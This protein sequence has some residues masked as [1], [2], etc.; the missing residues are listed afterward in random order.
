MKIILAICTLL[1][2]KSTIL[3]SQNNELSIFDDMIVNSWIGHY[4]DSEDSN[5]VH[6]LK[7]KYDLNKN[8]VKATKIVPEVDFKQETVFYYDYSKNQISFISF[9]NKEMISNGK[10]ELAENKILLTGSTYYKNGSSDFKI[11]YEIEKN[12]DLTDLFYRKKN[13]NW[14]QGHLIRYTQKTINP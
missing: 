12:G 5:L 10:A 6:I 13:G 1:I 7:W 11:T 8:V 2:L 9:I 4:Q 3:V 14:V